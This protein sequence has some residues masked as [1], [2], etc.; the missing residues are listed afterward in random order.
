MKYIDLINTFW[1]SAMINP[2]SSGQIALY[3]ALLTF[4]SKK[5]PT[6]KVGDELRLIP[7]S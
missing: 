6:S 1:D 3:F 2:L 4:S 7:P 5:S